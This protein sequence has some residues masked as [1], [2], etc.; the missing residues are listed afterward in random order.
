[1]KKLL[2]I[3]AAAVMAMPFAAAANDGDNTLKIVSFNIRVGNAND[4]INNW[5]NR[6]AACA[7]M[8]LDEQPDICGL[9]EALER[10]VNYLKNHCKGFGMLGISR[11]GYGT[12]GE[13]MSFMYNLETMEVL[14]WGTFWLSETPDKQ[15]KGWDGAYPRTAT[16][17]LMKDKRN[18][19]K[20]YY[21]NTHLD[22]V[23]KEAQSKGLSLIMDRIA[24]LNKAG[25]PFIIGGD[26]NITLENSSMAPIK[27]RMLNA[28]D[29]AKV[30][31]DKGSYNGWGNSNAKIDFIWYEGFSSCES[32]RT[33]TNPY[34]GC[35]FISD[36]YPIE[37]VFAY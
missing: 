14:E 16:W 12:K 31:D 20:F 29:N 34:L 37:A 17:A 5:N 15:S 30:S 13:H 6:S 18:G 27:A 23:G 22:H 19:R 2:L 24:D 11:D 28:R 10:Q 4:G 26:F 32:F 25:I 9:Q 21:V 33:N 35:E 8:V 1:M 7:Q 36:H 3:L